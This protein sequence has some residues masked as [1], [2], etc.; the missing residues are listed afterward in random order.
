[1]TDLSR[2]WGLLR[3][4]EP[5]SSPPQ[6]A[7]KLL[8]RPANTLDLGLRRRDD[9]VEARDRY[10]VGIG[11]RDRPRRALSR[12]IAVRELRPRMCAIKRVAVK[13]GVSLAGRRLE[14]NARGNPAA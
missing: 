14:R 13:H 12:H 11:D 7:N 2:C 4:R 8:L 1:M 9:F 6:S 3:F 10:G 5:C